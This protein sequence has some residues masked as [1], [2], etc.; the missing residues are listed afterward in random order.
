[1]TPILSIGHEYLVSHDLFKNTIILSDMVRDKQQKCLQ[2][3]GVPDIGENLKHV[4]LSK[5]ID[6]GKVKNNFLIVLCT[7]EEWMDNGCVPAGLVP[8]PV[9]EHQKF[10]VN[11]IILMSSVIMYTRCVLVVL[12]QR[13]WSHLSCEKFYILSRPSI[14]LSLDV[15]TIWSH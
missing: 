8:I 6:L 11:Y 7:L 10:D 5:P 2:Y 4:D 13:R 3:H 12:R 9:I 14:K 15:E 1:M